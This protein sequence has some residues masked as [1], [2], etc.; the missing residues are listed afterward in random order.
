MLDLQANKMQLYF[1]TKLRA[2]LDDE[3]IK[4]E[5][6]KKKGVFCK[7]WSTIMISVIRMFCYIFL[8]HFYYDGTIQL[9]LAGWK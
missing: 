9:R 6:G 8:Q 1:K 5:S 7:L 2:K 4:N 3:W